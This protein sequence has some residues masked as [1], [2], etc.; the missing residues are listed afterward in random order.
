MPT[1]SANGLEIAYQLVGGGDETILLING[2]ADEKES[3]GLQASTFVEAGYRV[4]SFDNRGIGGTTKPAG[5]YTTRQMADD[6]KSLI[7]ALGIGE[8]HLLGFSMG[9]MIA[10]EYAL[11]Y[12]DTLRSLVLYATYAE[13]G[14]YCLRLFETWET[15]ARNCDVESAVRDVLLWCFTPAFYEDQEQLAR[16]FDDGV[17]SLNLTAESFLGQL[18]AIQ[19][20]DAANRLSGIGAP[21]LVLAGEQDILIPPVQSHR[22]YERMVGAEWLT[23]PGGHAACWEF[24]ESFNAAVLGFVGRHRDEGPCRG[25]E[26][27]PAAG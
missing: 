21:T 15:L 20:H 7:D 11:A 13:P 9:G 4:L 14:P 10:Q 22:L 2:I 6:A 1:V 23:V 16:E 8:V 24:P 17:P 5:P 27:R 25:R 3:W 18:A 26:N 19:R 12:G